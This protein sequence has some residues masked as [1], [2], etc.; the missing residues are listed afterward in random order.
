MAQDDRQVLE[1]LADHARIKADQHLEMAIHW[2]NL[3]GPT[4]AEEELFK[5]GGY[6]RAHDALI[7][8]LKP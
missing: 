8:K 3:G 5:A 6:L 1:T 4:S 2:A 7:E